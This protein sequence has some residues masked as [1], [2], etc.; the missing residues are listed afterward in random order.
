MKVVEVVRL[1]D[2]PVEGNGIELSEDRDMMDPRIEAVAQG[3]VDQPVLA[4]DWHG[5]LGAELGEGP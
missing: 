3:D 2:M 5:R 1:R 4:A